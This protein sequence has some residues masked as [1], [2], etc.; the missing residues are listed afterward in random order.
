M[1][2]YANQ[3]NKLFLYFFK[4]EL[5]VMV[6]RKFT[7]ISAEGLHMRPAGVLTSEMCK[8]DCDVE[9]LYNGTT[10]NAKSLLNILASCIKCGA[11]IELRC[12][13]N[14]EKEALERAGELIQSDFLED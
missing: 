9:I 6:S 14:D 10:I 7:V 11:E 8:F 2:D 5:G 3:S 13:G 1:S 12:D 4:G